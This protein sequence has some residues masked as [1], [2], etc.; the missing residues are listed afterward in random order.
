ME[1]VNNNTR[2]KYTFESFAKEFGVTYSEKDY[3]NKEELLEIFNSEINGEELNP[4]KFNLNNPTILNNIGFYY[5]IVKK[6]VERAKEFY[7]KAIELN[8][9]DAIYN[10]GCLCQEC[11]DYDQMKYYYLKT[12]D[13][14][15]HNSASAAYRL[16]D[17][18]E[19]IEFN[20]KECI[21]CYLFANEHG[22]ESSLNNIGH[23]YHN[24]GDFAKAIEYSQMSIDKFNSAHSMRN[25]AYTHIELAKILDPEEHYA[26]T[27]RLFL[28]RGHF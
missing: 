6:D 1:Q 18:Y 15:K 22:C 27:E 17:Y 9:H 11:G 8:D 5:L 28:Q 14:K 12:M 26:E 25:L 19:T 7:Y 21:E 4:N 13:D 2:E 23:H 20:T 3:E 16:A 24:I 10:I